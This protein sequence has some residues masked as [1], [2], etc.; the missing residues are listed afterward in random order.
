M[1]FRPPFER[2]EEHEV[3]PSCSI[4][5]R[6]HVAAL[7]LTAGHIRCFSVT[8]SQRTAALARDVSHRGRHIM[9]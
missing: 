1:D 7:T 4:Y 5:L 3:T 6:D 9:A 8:D 2:V